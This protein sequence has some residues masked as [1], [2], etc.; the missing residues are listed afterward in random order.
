MGTGTALK[1]MS[2]LNSDND[3]P[4]IRLI[5]FYILFIYLFMCMCMSRTRS[6]AGRV[7]ESALGGITSIILNIN[8]Y[9]YIYMQQ[10]NFCRHLRSFSVFRPEVESY[11]VILYYIILYVCVYVY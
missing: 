8:T 3:K 9:I 6:G 2:S 5:S 11:Y 1:A 7:G 10:S 4:A